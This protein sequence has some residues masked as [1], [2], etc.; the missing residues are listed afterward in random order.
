M[1]TALGLLLLIGGWACGPSG[2][3]EAPRFEALAPTR[4]G[5]D[6]RNELAYSEAFNVYTYK[7]FYNGAGVG[8]GDVNNDGLP[9]L[10]FCG[11]MVDNRL[12][13]NRGDWRFEDITATAGVACPQ[14]WSSGVALADVNNDGHLDT[15]VCKSG[16]PGGDNRH[17]ELFV[18]D[19]NAAT[20]GGVPTFT[21][22]AAAWGI[23]DEG[24]STHAAFFDYDRDGDLDMYLLNNSLRPVGG[25]DIRR[26]LR[27]QRDTLGGNR[28]YRHDG[29]RY[30]DVSE[31]AGI[32]GSAI[33][34]GLGVTIGDVDRDGWQDIFVSNDFFERD[35]LYLNQRDGTFREDLPARMPEISMGSMG[36]DMADLNN[37]GF[38]EIFVT[39][40][41]PEADARMKTK[42]AFE[43]WDTYQRKVSNGYHHQFTRNTL[44][45]NR[46][47]GRFSEV[48]RYAG[49]AA[50]DWSWG[51][52]LFDM[53]N[54]GR[55]DIFV[56]N[57]IYKDLTDQD[58][59]NFYSDPATKRKLFEEK[60]TM[61]TTMI[62]AIPS[63]PLPNYAFRNEGGLRFQN[64][65]E[66]WG[67]ATPGFSNG[68]AYGDLDNDGD[69]D[70]VVNN[71]QAVPSIYRNRTRELDSTAHYIAFDLRRADTGAP[72][73]G[74]QVSV[75]ANGTEQY[76]EL[77]PMRGFQSQ[78]DGRLLFGLGKNARVDSVRVR[79]LG[80]PVLRLVRPKADRY[81]TLSVPAAGQ[82]ATARTAAVPVA[83]REL[84]DWRQPENR[85]SDFD[86]NRLLYHMQSTEGPKA[87]TADVNGDGRLDI[88]LGGPKGTA[89]RLLL[90][91]GQD[92]VETAQPAFVDDAGAEDMGVVFFDADGDADADLL[93]SSGGSEF[94][95]VSGALKDR[96]YLNDGAGKFTRSGQNFPRT[97]NS[98]A[99]VADIDGDGDLDLFSAERLAPFA[100]GEAVSGR[101][102]TNDGTGNFSDATERLAPALLDLGMLTDAQWL[103][104]DRDG[105][106]DLL[107][108]GE[109]MPIRLFENQDGRLVPTSISALDGAAGL[110]NTVEVADLNRDGLPDFVAGNLGLNTRLR[111][112]AAHP[113]TLY[114][115]DFDANGTADP[116]ITAYEGERALPLALRHDLVQQL[117]SLKKKY[118]KYADYRNQTI[119][120]LFGEEAVAAAHRYEVTTT[121]SVIGLN[122]GDGTFE[123]LTLP[124]DAQLMPVY[125]IRVMDTGRSFGPSLVLGGN[126]RAARPEIG[127]YAG[128]YLT[129]LHPT[130][131]G[132][133]ATEVLPAVGGEIRDL[134]H[135]TD[136]DLLV[137]RH[138]AAPVWLPKFLR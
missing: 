17:N 47:E 32:Y 82:V 18:N 59:V 127:G 49:V 126:L 56:A 83:M 28:L 136:Q 118:L 36:A 130:D 106:E 91:A 119:T 19:G 134:I 12:Y 137:I 135:P 84:P 72:A 75:Y 101:L 15:Y 39:D 112:D 13:L 90:A 63:E 80:G 35:Y 108:V 96:L 113:L 22:A 73:Y 95:N 9:D 29:D 37:D 33:G 109:W 79:P 138:D 68:S 67:L 23:A 69:L 132:H 92:F 40:M 14:V 52:L 94:S 102:Y 97:S 77:A 7:N 42:T 76:Q 117:P 61:L 31:E 2:S 78:V 8:I 111:A 114:V 100:Y 89:G 110:W 58:Y 65:A 88:Y 123:L 48:S 24:L 20:N 104:Y 1:R 60:G 70:L 16:S 133:Y 30:T 25:Y 43:T 51:A 71:V 44:H 26:G 66:A 131:E 54:D 93:V 107:V 6:F 46:G 4:T 125:A 98:C 129:V 57:G 27:E 116:L 120:D 62:D 87:A 128:G 86:R 64:V 105:D 85:F 34:F 74:V 38:P 21:E 99:R 45:L 50:T 41:L 81:H 3:T 115:Y 55:R 122:R 121:A 124:A 53:D 5:I 10:Y 103:D 11:N